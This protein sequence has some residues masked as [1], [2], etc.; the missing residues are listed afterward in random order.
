[1]QFSAPFTL[2]QYVF[3]LLHSFL[4]GYCYELFRHPW[5]IY[6]NN[7]NH[8]HH[9]GNEKTKQKWRRTLVAKKE[10]S[11]KQMRMLDPTVFNAGTQRILIESKVRPRGPRGP[12]QFKSSFNS[13]LFYCLGDA[14]PTVMALDWNPRGNTYPFNNAH[15]T[16]INVTVFWS[17]VVCAATRELVL[18]LNWGQILTQLKISRNMPAA[19]VAHQS[20][21]MVRN[22]C[23]EL[24]LNMMIDRNV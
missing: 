4:I 23:A 19:S 22:F 6:C 18:T 2:E 14:G 3:P 11:F 7:D 12:H 24:C 15:S 21:R 16:S 17:C 5:S 20:C 1:M 8:H 13:H 9:D 10:R